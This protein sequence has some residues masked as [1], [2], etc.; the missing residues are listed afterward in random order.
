MH[1]AADPEILKQ[2]SEGTKRKQRLTTLRQGTRS[3]WVKCGKRMSSRAEGD[4]A[5]LGKEATHR[6]SEQSVIKVKRF[7]A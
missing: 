2:N 1:A 4:L 5:S 3:H 7:G 6:I